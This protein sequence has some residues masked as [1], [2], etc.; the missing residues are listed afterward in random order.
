LNKHT[1]I[2]TNSPVIKAKDCCPDAASPISV[3][4]PMRLPTFLAVAE[5]TQPISARIADP[6]KNH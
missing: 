3:V 6:M 4:P 5:T 1:F 2:G